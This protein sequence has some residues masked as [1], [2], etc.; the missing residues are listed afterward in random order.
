MANLFSADS[1]RAAC[2][3]GFSRDAGELEPPGLTVYKDIGR[4]VG[5]VFLAGRAG[6]RVSL[7]QSATN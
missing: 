6:M 3:N 7:E 2:S 4:K 1:V 5:E